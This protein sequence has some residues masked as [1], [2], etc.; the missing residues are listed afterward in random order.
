MSDTCENKLHYRLGLDAGTTSL[1]WAMIR[2][3]KDGKPCAVI[4]A[5]SRIFSDGRDPQN[6][7]SLASVRRMAR[8][9][10]RTRDRKLRRKGK[11]IGALVDLGLFPADP[12]ERR[13]LEKLDPYQLRVKGL[14][15]ELSR[16]E[17]ARALFHLAQ[18]R[19]F[20]SNRKTDAGDE[21][22]GAL[23]A[24]VKE[25]KDRLTKSGYRTIGEWLLA[26]RES[27]K[28]TRARL[29]EVVNEKSKVEKVYDL[30]LDRAMVH[31]EFEQI[32]AK[33]AAFKPELLTEEAHER[34][35]DI[36]FFQRPLRPVMPGRCTL[37]PE[38][39]RAPLALPS[40]QRFRVYQELNNLRFL[41]S[42]LGEHPLSR[43]Q[44]D[45]IASQFEKSEKVTFT[46]MKKL[47]HYVGNFNLEDANRTELKGNIVSAILSKEKCYGTGW[48]QLTLARQDEIVAKLLETESEQELVS[49]LMAETG[50]DEAH[51]RAVS[52]AKLPKGYGSLSS[53]ALAKILPVLQDKVVTYDK[54]VLEA[55]FENHSQLSYLESTGEVL[56][57]LPYYGEYLTRHVGFG[58]PAADN[59]EERYGKIGNP[60]VH[61]CLNQ[62]RLV[63]NALIKKYG[64]PDEIIIEM[65]RDLK[66][67]EETRKEIERVQKQN[68]KKRAQVREQIAKVL[69]CS[70]ELVNGKDIEKWLL[71]E[72]LNLHDTTQ[73]LCPYSGRQISATDVLSDAIEIDHILPFSRT[74]DDGRSN[75]VVCYREANRIKGNRTPWEA[76][77]DFAAKGWDVQGMLAR[78]ERMASNK[79]FRFGESGYEIWLKDYGD[80]VARA[81]T[82]TQYISRVAKEYL[83]LICPKT[84]CIPGRLTAIL[85]G[86]FGL[87]GLLSS[88]G[89]KNR[90]DHRH[91]AIDA[92]VIGITD[93]GMLQ[94]FATANAQAKEE[95]IDKLV[96]SMPL[97]WPTYFTSV[98]RAIDAVKV[99]H[100][101]D[102]SHEGKML[103]ETA[104]GP[105]PSGMWA[106]KTSKKDRDPASLIRLTRD[107]ASWRHGRNAD[108]SAKAYKGY[109]GGSNYCIEITENE[110]G[111]WQSTVIST[112]E[113][114]QMVRRGQSLRG[115]IGK[116][117]KPV[118]LRLMINDCVRMN[119]KGMLGLYVVK[120]IASSGQVF[121]TPINEELEQAKQVSKGARSFQTS[122]ALLV[123]ISP[124]G[125]V[126]THRLGKN[127]E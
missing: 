105:R 124:I 37:I 81:L 108:G 23:K 68:Q 122:G 43:E 1:G 25:T 5:G 92:C 101:P 127:I 59:P 110:K 87:N 76:R 29:R 15:E 116:L 60:T 71:W 52:N 39:P 106:S 111:V 41:D 120:R 114:Y 4:R 100:R 95:G 53:K 50:L 66:N 126:H 62:I 6:H 2:L 3:D 69:G 58:D 78:A 11:L 63:V 46:R 19:G 42:N 18:R 65:A 94:K 33:Q 54:A 40:Q 73:R 36:I 26:R 102:H 72:E 24:A 51:A 104:Y 123:T 103:D 112:F 45:L 48:H 34:I 118:L 47:I 10:R 55:G 22:A 89:T 27:G 21:D 115:D 97:P 121:L 28:G 119:H 88:D 32:W 83:S 9:A 84:R 17:L 56:P 44:R 75:K 99:S 14:D 13:K 80:F 64:K 12:E 107:Q 79:G 61:I 35:E 30:Y 109:M 7:A 77:D 49:W 117:G 113:A 125:D 38:E 8:Q 98:S 86:K 70:E 16:Q 93:Q 90:N 57:N 96:K 20:K 82:D 85:R 74:L 91:H 31:D 67:G